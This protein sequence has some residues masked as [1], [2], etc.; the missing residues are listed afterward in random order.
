VIYHLNLPVSVEQKSC[1]AD[2]HQNVFFMKEP[3][4]GVNPI[5]KLILAKNMK[6]VDWKL[7]VECSNGMQM[8]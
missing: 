1:K 8:E 4:L 2:V 6:Y 7:K 3:L 5:K